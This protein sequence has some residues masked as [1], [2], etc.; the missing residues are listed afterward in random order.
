MSDQG[1][2]SDGWRKSSFSGSNN[3]CVEVRL[4]KNEVEVR[5][6]KR[7]QGYV[8]RFTTAEWSVFLNGVRAGEFDT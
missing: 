8:L 6:S 5:D 2:G 4:G 3:E 7:P 1:N